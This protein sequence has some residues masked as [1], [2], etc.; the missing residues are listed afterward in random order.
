MDE[1]QQSRHCSVM[2]A[3][4]TEI[5]QSTNSVHV[6]PNFGC[7]NE[8]RPLYWVPCVHFLPDAHCWLL[9]D[10]LHALL[11]SVGVNM[12]HFELK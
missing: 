5:P 3:H 1:K 10:K 7:R 12:K 8:G 9:F 11:S 6:Q 4:V 2:K